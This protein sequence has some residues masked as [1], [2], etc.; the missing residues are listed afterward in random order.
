MVKI[1]RGTSMH[2]GRMHAHINNVPYY[3]KS[4]VLICRRKKEFRERIEMTR[5]RGEKKS[6]EEKGEERRLSS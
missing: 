3:L 1:W 4:N 5:Q 6:S 2:R